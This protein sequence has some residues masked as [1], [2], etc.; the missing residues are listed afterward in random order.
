M[1]AIN[2]GKTEFSIHDKKERKALLNKRKAM[3]EQFYNKQTSVVEA[4]VAPLI[5]AKFNEVR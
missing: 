4:A 2:R 3:L 5:Q 1:L